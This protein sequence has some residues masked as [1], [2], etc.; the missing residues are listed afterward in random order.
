M[1]RPSD[2]RRVQA[3]FDAGLDA[4]YE[5]E[6]LLE[7][8]RRTMRVR[9]MDPDNQEI[10]VA[11]AIWWHDPAAP[12][13]RRQP[14]DGEVARLVTEFNGICAAYTAAKAGS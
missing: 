3:A 9:V 6:L 7:D 4:P 8:G 10:P 14:D 1:F 2:E 12:K 5:A 13:T 11:Q